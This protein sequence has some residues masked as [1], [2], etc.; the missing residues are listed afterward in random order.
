MSR[1]AAHVASGIPTSIAAAVSVGVSS[2]F[3]S[4]DIIARARARLAP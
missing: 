4:A 3:A 1:H 2:A